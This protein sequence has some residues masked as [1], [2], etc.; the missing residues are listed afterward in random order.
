MRAW[1]IAALVML[2]GGGAAL[3]NVVL[4]LREATAPP[5]PKAY[6]DASW[7]VYR[8]GPGHRAHVGQLHLACGAC[9]SADQGELDRPSPAL[10]VSC[11]EEQ[12]EIE[13][14]TVALNAEGQRLDAGA[15]Q[16]ELSDCVSCHG[17]GPDPEQDPHDCQS[18]HA[19]RQGTLNPIEAHADAPC[20]DCHAVHENRVTPIACRQ[21]HEV[22]VAHG[23][24]VGPEAETACLDCHA[25]HASAAHAEASCQTCHAADQPA[26]VPASA[27]TGE[28]RCTGCHRKHTFDE[29]VSCQDCHA[30]QHVLAAKKHGACA[31]CHDPHDPVQS[32]EEPGLCLR[33]HGKVKLDHKQL[34]TAVSSRDC[35]DCHAV[36]KR[37]VR[38]EKAC[39]S[40]HPGVGQGGLAHGQG[41]P[42]Q[43]CHQPH[44]FALTQQPATCA[45]C[46]RGEHQA[47]T[48][49]KGHSDCAGCH[50]NL[51]HGHELTPVACA[52]CH[53]EQAR[54]IASG[55]AECVQCH[56]PHGGRQQTE[57]ATC[58]AKEATTHPKGHARCA[59]CH[60]P[61]VSQEQAGAV[62]CATCHRAGSLSGLHKLPQHASE[63]CLGCHAAHDAVP[64]AARARCLRCHEEQR[65]HQPEAS[66][67]DGCHAFIGT[68]GGPR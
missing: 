22:K 58:H 37:A 43:T 5:S 7:Q 62:A 64:P 56:E 31:S 65:D 23:Q 11:H 6:V 60:D 20:V 18:C 26:G 49:R 54:Q 33:C 40:C 17:F 41:Q 42:C 39:A 15:G 55:H 14:L 57:C 34:E 68:R 29:P 25:A 45:H 36:H 51:P 4:S 16:R 9:H 1:V 21:C 10:C 8:F 38:P 2:L 52:R 46:H 48:K 19:Q 61:H 50:Q 53:E 3:V 63:P 32:A 12:A 67:C 24:K 35:L 30:D 47:A 44:Q 28:H 27:T 59:A 66:R 13:H